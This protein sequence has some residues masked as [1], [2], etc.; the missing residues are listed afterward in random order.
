MAK[1][2]PAGI[3]SRKQSRLKSG[4]KASE[5]EAASTPPHEIAERTNMK[6]QQKKMHKQSDR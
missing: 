5:A 2:R 3:E 6:R 4:Q 1:Q